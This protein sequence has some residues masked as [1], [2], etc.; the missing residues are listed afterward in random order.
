M[1]ARETA[2]NEEVRFEDL[3]LVYITSFDL[4]APVEAEDLKELLKS[5]SESY[6][7]VEGIW[8]PPEEVW[9]TP[10]FVYRKA[11]ELGI[12]DPEK[13]G[14]EELMKNERLEEEINR[15]LV[16]FGVILSEDERAFNPEYLK[17]GRY[18][19][20]K[21]TDL[22]VSIKD[23]ELGYLNELKYELY[24]LLHSAG[25]GVLT[26]RI[27]LNG[28]FSTDDLIKIEKKLYE[29]ECM[30]KDLFGNI[31]G[32][33]RGFIVQ[34]IIKPLQAAVLFKDEYGSY[35]AAFDALEKGDITGDKI[36]EK[37][38][39]PYFLFRRGVCIRKHSCSY[40][41]KTA[42]E[43]VE[44][45][46]REIAGIFGAHGAWR[47]WREG[48]AR[49]VLGK[50]LSGDVYYAMF[51]THG[52][53]S[54]F[55][56]SPTLD[57]RLKSKRDEELAYRKREL[58]L[59]QPMEFLLLSKMI[60]EVYN[61]VCRNKFKK[62]REMRRREETV[63]PSEIVKIRE[64]LVEGLEEYRNVSLFRADPRRSIMEYGKKRLRLSDE[65]NI[66]KS[67]L[68]ELDDMSRTLYEEETLKK[69]ED[70]S[71]A[72]VELAARQED[73]SRKQLLLTILFGVFGAFQAMEY[74]EPRLGFLHAF[75]VTLAIFTLI[76]L[77]YKLYIRGKLHL[78]R[79][80]KA[81]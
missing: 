8:I 39:T 79:R 66:L 33:L 47:Y 19:R 7:M 34:N 71:R 46:L 58:K 12:E 28:N 3:D 73:L 76:Y 5:L 43:A 24:L 10:E 20:L 68:E 9:P 45:H 62:I 37:L 38:R 35:D 40:K 23:K 67:L 64:G 72:Q 30:I 6:K 77:S 48:V 60:L 49:E 81:G 32:T 57:E 54:L 44:R 52:G 16:M 25:V 63:K 1:N 15:A 21:L 74:L 50:N 41:C 4:G 13:I 22:N 31:E 29:A 36:K 14:I 55:L 42:E 78:F 75:A 61:S 11:K 2:G 59:V 56:G 70:F 69:Q 80:K 27:H 26:A 17:L 53:A 65:V 18:V 51:V